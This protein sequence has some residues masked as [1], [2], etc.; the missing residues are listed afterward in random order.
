MP[1]F[2]RTKHLGLEMKDYFE[3]KAT[4]DSHENCVFVQLVQMVMLI[5]VSN[6]SIM[7]LRYNFSFYMLMDKVSITKA[8][9]A[10]DRTGGMHR[11]LVHG[12]FRNASGMLRANGEIHVNH[13]TTAPFSHWN[14]EELAS[15]DSLV[16]FE[17]VDFKKEDYPGYNNKRGAGSRCDEP[18]P[19]GAC[20]TFKFRF[21]PI[22]MKMSRIVC[23]SDL[24]HRGSQQINLMQMQQ[25]PG[26]SD[27]RG[28]GRN[29]LANMNGI[30]RHMGLPLTIFDGYFNHA[31]ETFGRNGYDVGYTVHEAFRLGFERY[32]AE[33]P[34]RTLTGYINLLQELQHLSRLRSAFLQRMLLG[35]DHYL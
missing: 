17:C 28:P 16:L 33:G 27:Y 32:M 2:L 3:R 13:K 9:A 23:H 11:D 12:F 26:S 31:V 25:W 21:S 29:I 5:K 8:R 20:G 6:A 14:L 18:F 24:N 30:P 7:R 35:P 10:K 4:R 1:E 34:G 22:A 15:Q 19:L